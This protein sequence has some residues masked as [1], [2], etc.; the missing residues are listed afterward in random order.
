MNKK[1]ENHVY[2]SHCE[3]NNMHIDRDWSWCSEMEW[4]DYAKTLKA[5]SYNHCETLLELPKKFPPKMLFI[6][7]IALYRLWP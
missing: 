7:T 2:I 5:E 6:N 1:F 3:K 4:K